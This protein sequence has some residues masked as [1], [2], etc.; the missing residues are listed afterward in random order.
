MILNEIF[1]LYQKYHCM[2]SISINE[3]DVSPYI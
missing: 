3:D 2:G 1:N